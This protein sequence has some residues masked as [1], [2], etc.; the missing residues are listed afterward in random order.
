MPQEFGSSSSSSYIYSICANYSPAQAQ[1][2]VTLIGNPYMYTAREYDIE[3]GLYY[4]RARYYNPYIGRFLQTD[5]AYQGMNWYAYCGNDPL[6]YTDPSGCMSNL[7]LMIYSTIM[8][9]L[10]TDP[11]C[12]GFITDYTDEMFVWYQGMVWLTNDLSTFGSDPCGGFW[13]VHDYNL[14]PYYFPGTSFPSAPDGVDP[15]EWNGPFK[16][17]FHKVWKPWNLKG[18]ADDTP[19]KDIVDNAYDEWEDLNKPKVDKPKDTKHRERLIDIGK[20]AL[21][22]LVYGVAVSLEKLPWSDEQLITGGK[23]SATVGVGAAI[24]AGVIVLGPAEAIAAFLAEMSRRPELG[25]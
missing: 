22:G 13:Y 2:E 12:L 3:T 15:K 24:T 9:V 7:A 21:S 5:P 20:G 10:T 11:C 17:W 8:N 6:N 1:Q 4:Y 23:V 18:P 14:V 16:K 19:Y 25:Y